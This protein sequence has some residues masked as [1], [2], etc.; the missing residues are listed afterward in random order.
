M[1][2]RDYVSV[3]MRMTH[4]HKRA[5]K[6]RIM[7]AKAHDTIGVSPA[8]LLFGQSINIYSGLLSAIPPESLIRGL[9]DAAGSRLSNHVAKLV[10]V[11]KL[12]E[13]ARSNQSAANFGFLS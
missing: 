8:E 13:V 12:I 3:A 6:E 1:S 7:N 5:N 10:K 2:S 4:T 11:H 9:D